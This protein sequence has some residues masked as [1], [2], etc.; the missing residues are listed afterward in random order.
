MPPGNSFWD[1]SLAVYR[2]PGVSEACLR[3]QDD[4]GVDVNLLL[5]VCWLATVRDAAL[6]EAGVR[7]AI[8]L[9]EGWRDR[10]VRPLRD[11]RRWMKGGAEGMPAESVEALRSEVKK[12][13]LKSE[14][15][16]QDM[17]FAMAG[18]AKAATDEAAARRRADANIGTYLSVIGAPR[19]EQ[20][21]H[22][23]HTVAAAS[24]PS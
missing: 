14:R 11:V 1:Y 7:D 5:Y 9:T 6:D 24:I 23:R 17:L 8:A 2:R 13:E 4:A 18:P 12:I 3:L 22:A 15:L 21:S 16:Q 10:V 19:T 20:I